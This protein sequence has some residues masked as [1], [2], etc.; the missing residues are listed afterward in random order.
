MWCRRNVS[1]PGRL[2][3]PLVTS[4]FLAGCGEVTKPQSDASLCPQ[5]AE[6]GNF[7]CADVV[8]S[9]APPPQPWPPSFLWFVRAAP[10]RAGTGASDNEAPNA[11]PGSVGVRLTRWSLPAQGSGDTA[12]FWISAK[13]LSI[14]QLGSSGVASV[15]AA[16][17]VLRVLRFVPVGSRAWVESVV[18]TPK[19]VTRT[20]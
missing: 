6:F 1:L 20:E 8:I 12:S 2:S 18:L 5:T 9:F 3:I 15:F 13:M 4:V 7:G 19:H 17:S 16:D 14:P 10:A 11:T